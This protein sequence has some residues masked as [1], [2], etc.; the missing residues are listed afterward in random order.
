MAKGTHD[1]PKEESLRRTLDTMAVDPRAANDRPYLESMLRRLGYSEHEIREYLGSSRQDLALP[2]P[3]LA[4]QAPNPTASPASVHS[5]AESGH[6]DRD[7]ELEYTGPGLQA[8]KLVTGVD[9]EELDLGAGLEAG[10]EVIDLG[11]SQEEVDRLAAEGGFGDFDNWGEDGPRE[12][13]AGV[14]AD[15]S[16][17]TD[18]ETLSETMPDGTPDG[19]SSGTAT[20]T[21]AGTTGPEFKSGEDLV[22]F[23]AAELNRGVVQIVDPAADE[24]AHRG[25]LQ[26]EGW[27]VQD[28]SGAFQA[29]NLTAEELAQA[30]AAPEAVQVVEEPVEAE[31]A[32][33]MAA[34]PAPEMPPE[35]G[36]MA[37]DGW[38]VQPPAQAAGPEG[39]AVGEDG[40]YHHGPYTLYKRDEVREG[41][42]QR[43]FF[44]SEDA[45]DD[46]QPSPVPDGYEVAENPATGRPFLRRIQDQWVIENA[47]ANVD[48]SGAPRKRIRIKRVHAASRAEAMSQI[49]QE[50]GRP[51]HSM[52]IDI[53]KRL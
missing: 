5:H 13:D 31:V 6:G 22:E 42:A 17:P 33:D 9:E 46:A 16:A 48:P 12:D 10:T 45:V 39:Y 38:N 52:P 30:G 21:Q 11:P 44:F 49:E 15:G 4:V 28:E 24:L 7:I 53:E 50:G 41:M 20:E 27:E 1:L 37:D 26:A 18:E 40:G 34:D 51:L 3:A 36:T 14:T 32:P 29:T 25:E 19:A 47:N 2:P 35:W 43:V 23:A 8:F